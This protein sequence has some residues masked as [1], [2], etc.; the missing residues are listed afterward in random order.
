MRAGEQA[1]RSGI[2]QA[3]SRIA[4]GL[5]R[6]VSDHLAL[7]RV[8][9][10]EDARTFAISAAR[11]AVFVPLILVGYGFLCA[12]LAVAVS[13]WIG[14]GWALFAVGFLNVAVG[15]IG[16]RVALRKVQGREVLGETREEVSR[17]AEVLA[18]VGRRNG[19]EKRLE[20]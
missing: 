15:A 3:M 19:A 5:S 9:L 17:S 13:R 7:A 16:V 20:A 1:D 6:L 11:I 18:Q 12:A 10:R 14:L 8:E 4:D 2:A